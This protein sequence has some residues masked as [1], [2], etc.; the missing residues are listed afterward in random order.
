MEDELLIRDDSV[1]LQPRHHGQVGATVSSLV[2]GSNKPAVV[3]H[4]QAVRISVNE[5]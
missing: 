2:T 1:N 3:A 4:S 5:R